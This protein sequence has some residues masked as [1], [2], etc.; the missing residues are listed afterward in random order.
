MSSLYC[1]FDLKPAFE[2]EIEGLPPKD[3]PPTELIETREKP[4]QISNKPLTAKE[5]E[6][7]ISFKRMKPKGDLLEFDLMQ[8]LPVNKWKLFNLSPMEVSKYKIALEK[9]TK[10]LEVGSKES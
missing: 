3:I 4:M 10:H 8:K 2:N 6:F 9:L 7:I 1:K 5:K